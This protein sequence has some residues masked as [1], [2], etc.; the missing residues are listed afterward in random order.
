MENQGQETVTDRGRYAIFGG[1]KLDLEYEVLELD[2]RVRP[3]NGRMFQVLKLLIESQ[4]RIVTKDDFFNRV[5]EGTS[6]EDNNL[7]V[8][9]TALRKA[10]DDDAKQSRF[11]ANVPRKGYRFVAAVI[12]RDEIADTAEV[13]VGADRSNLKVL[14]AVL[15][16]F[17]VVVAGFGAY[18]SLRSSGN[19]SKIKSIAIL[20]FERSGSDSDYL[21]DG[22]SAGIAEGL[23]RTIGLKVL[24]PEV[25]RKADLSSESV[26]KLNVETVLTG[27]VVRDGELLTITLALIDAG[28]SKTLW[29]KELKRRPGELADVQREAISELHEFLGIP[30][31]ARGTRSGRPTNDPEAYDLYIRGRYLWNKRVNQDI[32]RS[33]ELFRAAIDRDP[34]FAKAYVALADAYTLGTHEGIT[35][36]E[37]VK[38]ARGAIQKALEIDDT[39]GEAYSARAINR[40]FQDWDFSGAESDYKRAVELNPNDATTHHWYAELLSMLGRFD[41]SYSEYEKAIALDP[42][43]PVI[44]SDLAYAYYCAH[45]FDRAI[46]ELEKIISISPEF[47]RSYLVLDLVLREKGDFFGAIDVGEKYLEIKRRG[48]DLD[49]KTYKFLVRY[50]AELRMETKRNGK[51]GYWRVSATLDTREPY[52]EAVSKAKLGENDKAFELL[53]QAYRNR[54]TSLVWLKVTPEIDNLRGDPRFAN[55]LNRVGF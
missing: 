9:I 12:Y 21:A 41:E 30:E 27:G 52:I 54:S 13:R 5:W 26:E 40:V 50:Y 45:D 7:T 33:A 6:V 32:L 31:I 11:I 4:G 14:I 35:R 20:T 24:K 8:T 19:V 39:I 10:L 29:S 15:G 46:Q 44:R 53:E 22:L 25:G 38:L 3:I 34:T 47:V 51:E 49:G 43:S 48:G 28:T 16:L 55:L 23:S 2:G 1:F 36:E 17:I 18:W 37:Q 42:L